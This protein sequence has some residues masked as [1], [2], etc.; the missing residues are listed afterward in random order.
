MLETDLSAEVVIVGGGYSGLSAAHALQQRGIEP[1]VLEARTV[2]WG[3]SGRNGG[4]V[5]AKFRMSFPAIAR[6]YGLETARRMHRIAHES[7]EAVEE[8]IADLAI[9]HARFE[10]TGNLRCAHTQRALDALIAEAQWLRSELK[11]DSC[12]VLSRAELAEELGS[13]AFVGGV[14]HRVA[15]T[16]HPLNYARGMAAGLAARKVRVFENSP[17][18]RILPE[19]AGVVV[20]TPGGRVR[21][22]Q[23]LIATEAYSELTSATGQVSRS[24]IPF[25]SAII[26]TERMPL[27]LQVKLL[28]ARRGYSETRRMMKWF[29]KVDGRFVFGG[30]GAFGREDTASSFE[31]LRRAMTTLFPELEGLAIDFQWSG[32]VGMTLNQLPRVGRI[33]DRT[34]VCFGYNGVGIAMATLLGRYAGSLI[35]G[36]SPQLALLD[37]SRQKPVPFHSLRTPGVRMVAGWYQMLDALGR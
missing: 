17:V 28:T 25:R 31:A 2:G 26:A 33:D 20:E 36:E 8:L 29:R 7:L 19:P 34:C 13:D 12:C 18:T 6:A 4:V 15:G 37:A 27:Y 9:A 23:V 32:L 10:R 5:S 30:R 14:L 35:A 21:A 3:A 1:V 11:D 16:I 24:I 22:R